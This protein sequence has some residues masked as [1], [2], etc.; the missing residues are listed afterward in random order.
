MISGVRLRQFRS[1]SDQAF[2]LESGVNIVVGPNASGKTNL[3]ESLYVLAQG[4]SFRARDKDLVMIGR[5]WAR[6]ESESENSKRSVSLENSGDKI[7]K[8]IS[9]DASKHKRLPTAKRLPVVLF[10]PDHLQLLTGSPERRRN[11]LDNLI[12][13][14]FPTRSPVF[15]RYQRALQQRNSLL[16]TDQIDKDQLFVWNVKLAELGSKINLW[17]HQLIDELNKQ[18]SKTYSEISNQSHKVKFTYHDSVKR[19]DYQ[20]NLNKE[21]E[22]HSDHTAGFTTKGPHREDFS[23]EL[24]SKDSSVSASRGETRSL[25]LVTKIVE[26]LLTEQVAGSKPLLLLDDVF[27]ELD[28]AR[29]RHLAK[30][31][32]NYQTVITTTDADAVVEHFSQ[33]KQ[34]IIALV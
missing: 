11:Y 2:E 27:S 30:R 12:S 1:Y 28:G 3:L 31:L 13:Q 10:V 4:K 18:A 15:S 23:I 20:S 16:K 7:S 22:Q 33:D 6:I 19:G 21:L 17:R 32:A 34:H 25:V 14:L 26:M 9:V 29:R 5:D 24:D 8:T